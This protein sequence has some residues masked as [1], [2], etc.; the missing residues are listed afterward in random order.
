M[1]PCGLDC[2]ALLRGETGELSLFQV[3]LQEGLRRGEKRREG[4][5]KEE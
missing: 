2:C 1:V 5:R 3:L 4:R